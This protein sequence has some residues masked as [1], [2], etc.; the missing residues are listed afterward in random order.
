MFTSGEQSIA[1]F[2]RSF[3]GLL[4]QSFT[5][6]ERGCMELLIEHTAKRSAICK[7]MLC[8]NF[9]N[10]HIRQNQVVK[11]MGKTE[12]VQIFQKRH[13]HDFLE[14]TAKVVGL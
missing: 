7:A 11:N 3:F 2:S 8:G 6:M 13:A 10:V 14:E 1:V 5:K 4:A 9:S 12:F